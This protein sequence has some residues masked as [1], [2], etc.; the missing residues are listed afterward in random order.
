MT[1]NI[2]SFIIFFVFSVA[3]AQIVYEGPDDPASDPSNI[4]DARMDGNR[5]LLYFKNTTQLSNW[6]PGGLSD[7]SIWPNDPTGTRMVDGIGL[8]IGAKVYIYNDQDSTTLD[9]LI[10]DD[11]LAIAN[12][13]FSDPE[14][15]HEAYFLQTEYREEVDHNDAGTV[16]WTLQPVE[17][18]FNPSQNYPAMSDDPNSWPLEGWP[19]TGS[20][21]QWAGE[22]DGR[23]GRGV[24]YADLEAY[25]VANDAQDQEYLQNKWVYSG[26]TMPESCLDPYTNID[27]CNV[28]C[29]SSCIPTEAFEYYPRPDNFIQESA[30]VQPGLPWGG[31]GIRVVARA[32]QWNNPLVRDAL[33]WEYNIF[34]VSDHDITE[35]AFGYW[36]DNAI[37]GENA[38]DEYGYFETDL[39]LSYSWDEDGVG[40]AGST[41]GIMGFAFLESPGIAY[42]NIDNDNDGLLNEERTNEAGQLIG[43]YDGIYDITRFLEFYGYEESELKEHYE[44]DEDQDWRPP[45]F[46]E[47][48]NCIQVN[49]DVG[50]DGVGPNDVNY[51]EPDADGTECDGRPSTDGLKN[52][53]PNFATTDVS[54]SDMLGLTTFQLFRIDSHTPSSTTKWF[55]NDD[56][57]WNMMQDT[58]LMQYNASSSNLVELF[59]SGKFQLSKNQF[60]HISM[61]E[62]HS[63]DNL[64]GQPGGQS[65]EAT[66]LFELKKTVQL[67][68]ESDYR[69]AQPPL[70]PT[71][72]AEAGDNKVI[73]TWNNISEFSR[74]PFLPDSIQYDFEGYKIYR[75]TDKYLK[76]AQNITD[77]FGN[78]M[79]YEP[80]F[81]CDKIDGITGFSDWA[82]VFGTSY[83]LGDD[84]GIEHKYIDTDV[85]NGVTYYYAV[86][87]YDY[88]VAPNSQI[89]SGIPPSENNAI[90]ELDENEYVIGIGQNVAVVTPAAPSAGYIDRSIDVE[91][92]IIGTGNIFVEITAPNAI[93]DDQEYFITFTNETD[94]ENYITANGLTVHK[95]LDPPIDLGC[96][97]GNCT[98]FSG[99]NECADSGCGWSEIQFSDGVFE[100]ILGSGVL[101]H[102]LSE[103][104]DSL[105]IYGEWNFPGLVYLTFLNDNSCSKAIFLYGGGG[106]VEVGTWYSSH[107]EYRENIDCIGTA[108]IIN[109][110]Q[111]DL[112]V[113]DDSTFVFDGDPLS[114]GQTFFADYLVQSTCTNNSNCEQ[115][116]NEQDCVATSM[117]SWEKQYTSLIYD[118]KPIE[119]W[120]NDFPGKNLIHETVNQANGLTYEYWTLNPD[121]EITTDVFEGVN[122]RINGNVDT[123]R[124]VD[125]GGEWIN[126]GETNRANIELLFNKQLSKLEPWDY[127]ITWTGDTTTTKTNLTIDTSVIIIDEQMNP[128]EVIGGNFDFLVMNLFSGDTLDMAVKDM[129]GN[130]LYDNVGDKILVGK[131]QPDTTDNGQDTLEWVHTN[132]SIIFMED[133]SDGVENYPL[134]GDELLISFE[135]PFWST[136]TVQFTTHAPDTVS[137]SAHNSVMENIKVVPNPYVGTNKMEEAI[138]NTK[139][140]QRRKLIFTHLPMRCTIHIFTVSGTLVDR[141]QV[142]NS[143]DNGQTE[144]DLLTNEGL[145]IAAGMY[146]YHVRSDI[147]GLEGQ[148]KMGKFAVIK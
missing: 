119:G 136:D 117:C 120:V 14:T 51:N 6:E 24:K 95:V 78:P 146:I 73:L 12:S 81:Q 11:P 15:L 83:Y 29:D 32:F 104:S 42:D 56:V 92:N 43:P 134:P 36:V 91:K 50:L 109:D 105:T 90:I 110:V 26:N 127:S 16:N 58:L 88:G 84:S 22:W 114:S 124:V 107:I 54:E 116:Y 132:F 1:K 59:A 135:R 61:A 130:G 142:N 103:T 44:G 33:F 76:D 28:H 131:T 70:A 41:P 4:R 17:G 40:F 100:D 123:A 75:S 68:Y 144:W 52:S 98:N 101:F 138:F 3:T 49:D 80:L 30:S 38:D 133:P 113:S 122:I 45:V 141:I 115:I 48:G 37:G 111:F 9:T 125:K 118:E 86:V 55:K 72:T 140:N 69:F 27:S 2:F 46:D 71:L 79:F 129:N 102:F 8:L 77:G 47:Q 60:E 57:M 53:E 21:K 143:I 108:A 62:L 94:N 97:S 147:P 99:E 65:Q 18:Y 63:F 87:A 64:T 35:V 66:A 25:F 112:T 10:I 31:L 20:N 139:Y 145:E 13:L 89:E 19:Y 148:E 93:I 96:T 85:Q 121:E 137:P 39:D 5:I 23:F 34:N 106:L 67:I 74:D 82:P 7:V 126:E 128:T